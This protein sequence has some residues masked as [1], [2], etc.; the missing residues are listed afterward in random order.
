MQHQ[1]VP[2]QLLMIRPRGFAFNA[3]TVTSNSFQNA[4]DE[5]AHAF[6]LA[7]FNSVVEQLDQH[8]IS[9]HVFEDTV[10]TPDAL[11]LNNWFSAHATGEVVL[12]PMMAANRR[13]ERRSDVVTWLG[14]NYGVSRV[15]D[16]SAHEQHGS[17]LEGTGSLVLDHA[18]RVAYAN[19]SPRTSPQLVEEWCKQLDYRP[20]I[21]T[22][23]DAKGQPIYHTNVL[24][25][26]G[27]QV[28]AVC[29]DAIPE[30]EQEYLIANLGAHHRLV[31]LSFDQMAAFAGN[32]LEVTSRNGN[33][34]LLM[35]DTAMRSLVPGQVRELAR[36]AELLPVSIPTI[37]R[38][39]GGGIR[40]MVAGNHLPAKV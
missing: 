33:P 8:D 35:S 27:Q 37:E 40:C 19:R 12:Y 29:L 2:H 13:M 5:R 28:A 3:Q 30:Q 26:I 18:N 14:E 34:Y 24:L 21:F 7:E 15:L 9:V 31:S 1:Q 23:L 39:G 38:V 32:V 10:G 25:W 17:F 6:A 22:A 4:G 16:L 36:H 20:C 11:F